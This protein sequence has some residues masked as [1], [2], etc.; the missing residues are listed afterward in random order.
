MHLARNDGWRLV[1]GLVL[2]RRGPAP[3]VYA[4]LGIAIIEGGRAAEKAARRKRQAR[5]SLG[6]TR[7]A[8]ERAAP[9]RASRLARRRPPLLRAGLARPRCARRLL[10]CARRQ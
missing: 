1:S 3:R 6:A 10:E 8:N 7:I 4:R 5:T 9:K 2:S